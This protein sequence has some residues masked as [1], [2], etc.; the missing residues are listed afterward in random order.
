MAEDY[1]AR[2]RALVGT[3]FRPQGRSH[4]GLDCI[5][6][7]IVAFELPADCARKD[8][9]L[10]GDHRREIEGGLAEYFRKIRP[11]QLRAGDLMLMAVAPNQFHLGIRTGGGFVH[12]HAGLGKVVETPGPPQWPLLAAY[13]KRRR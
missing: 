9:R 10:S 2:A 11:A 4:D 3:R 12:A 13:R 1:A 6:T 5:G 7:V 8:Y